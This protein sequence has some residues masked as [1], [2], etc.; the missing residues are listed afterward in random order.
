MPIKEFKYQKYVAKRTLEPYKG[1]DWKNDLSKGKDSFLKGLTPEEKVNFAR[2]L[3]EFWE[4]NA[5]Q[6]VYWNGINVE[7]AWY[8]VME[9]PKTGLYQNY[10]KF[11]RI[12][13]EFHK[14]NEFSWKACWFHSYA[15]AVNFIQWCRDEEGKHFSWPV[16][17]PVYWDEEGP[18]S[19]PRTIK[20]QIL[21]QDNT[22]TYWDVYRESDVEGPVYRDEA[23]VKPEG[24]LEASV[25]PAKLV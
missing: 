19:G 5:D 7:K 22:A 12:R 17:F 18:D 8:M 20:V 23:S 16:N 3:D 4:K 24:G 6:Y 11:Q 10:G 21:Y 13:D 15:D 14:E 1:Y 25:K 9:G 2:R